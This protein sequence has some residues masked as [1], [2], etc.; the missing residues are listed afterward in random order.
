MDRKQIVRAIEDA[1]ARADV[2]ALDRYYAID[3]IDHD[4][5]P[6]QAPGIVGLKGKVAALWRQASLASLRRSIC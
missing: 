1:A 3:S 4:P 2:D 5:F 6:D